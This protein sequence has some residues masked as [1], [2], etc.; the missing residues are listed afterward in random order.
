MPH[1]LVAQAK[2]CVSYSLRSRTVGAKALPG[3]CGAPTPSYLRISA[4]PRAVRTGC[5]GVCPGVCPAYAPRV[6][7]G[8][9]AYALSEEN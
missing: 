9:P 6:H 1:R 7:I 3:E 8:C 4:A 2:P 5:P